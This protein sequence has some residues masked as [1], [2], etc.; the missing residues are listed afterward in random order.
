MDKK[1]FL[2]RL[3]SK[4]RDPANFTTL[5]SDSLE[6]IR[7]I[8]E[9][10]FPITEERS[11]PSHMTEA[12]TVGD[13][14]S[15]KNL[16][17][18]YQHAMHTQRPGAEFEGELHV[19][20]NKPAMPGSR[21]EVRERVLENPFMDFT[22]YELGEKLEVD[23]KKLFEEKGKD[24]SKAYNREK[25]NKREDFIIESIASIED[26]DIIATIK[27]IA[28]EEP[29]DVGGDTPDPGGLD[30]GGEG[31]GLG[32]DSPG[33]GLGEG[34]GLG[35]GLPD[36]G[37]GLGEN[38]S[39]VETEAIVDINPDILEA[40]PEQDK[41]LLIYT[42]NKFRDI[43][44]KNLS[45]ISISE[46]RSSLSLIER[47]LVK[48]KE[49]F[50]F[51]EMGFKSI[52][53]SENKIENVNRYAT[54]KK[55]ADNSAQYFAE[56]VTLEL[57]K[58]GVK[59]SYVST[60][61]TDVPYTTLIVFYDIPN[62]KNQNLVDEKIT[63]IPFKVIY[64]AIKDQPEYIETI[65]G[66]KFDFAK[67]AI[68]NLIDYYSGNNIDFYYGYYNPQFMKKKAEKT[69]VKRNI[70]EKLK[71]IGNSKEKLDFVRKFF[72][73]SGIIP[74]TETLTEFVILNEDGNSGFYESLDISETVWLSPE[75]VQEAR[76]LVEKIR[77][78]E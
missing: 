10:K 13:A 35:L 76:K 28:Q 73:K 71:D 8:V 38:K 19:V 55:I 9:G 16:V 5:N 39:K 59:P 63:R 17:Q 53:E 11:K 68:D 60:V 14:M 6:Y 7:S 36:T 72:S 31:G 20:D 37:L 47:I 78:G 46:I 74:L 50:T 34:G 2:E 21:E 23:L 22:E 48:A 3:R 69:E 1:K 49:N 61:N 77:W 15:R 12:Q 75:E 45:E 64:N 57:L 58:L 40:L 52:E 62:Y 43:L 51:K 4:Y 24:L 41:R 30:L 29:T 44:T 65:G 18:E 56:R 27:K 42:L 25:N 54:L 70:L 33:L 66:I 32:L 26:A 67:E